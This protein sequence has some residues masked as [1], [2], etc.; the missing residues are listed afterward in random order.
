[1]RSL[2]VLLLLVPSL[3]AADCPEPVG[4]TALQQAVEQAEV[5]FGTADLEGFQAAQA[6]LQALLPCLE[7][8]APRNLAAG[9]H[10]VEALRAFADREQDRAVGAFAAARAIE[11]GYAMPATVV[12]DGHPVRGL[13]DQS[14]SVDVVSEA[15]PRPAGAYLVF[16]GRPSDERPG[17]VPTIAQLVAEDGAVRTSAYLWPGDALFP[18]EIAPPGSD[19]VG[20]RARRGNPKVPLLVAAG[21]SGVASGV[22]FGLAGSTHAQYTGHELPYEDGDSAYRRNQLYFYTGSATAVVSA[23]LG[24]VGLVLSP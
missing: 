22:M 7:S 9:V 13:Y 10:R 17:N 21:A 11:P 18:Y 3:A 12:P 20:P 4:T 2:S 19:P 1:M 16:D 24:V 14:E 15:A 23:T 8:T 6:R 5:A